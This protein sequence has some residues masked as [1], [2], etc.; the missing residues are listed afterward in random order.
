MKVIE[1]WM[2]VFCWQDVNMREGLARCESEGRFGKCDQAIA[3]EQCFE[4]TASSWPEI[5]VFS[6]GMGNQDAI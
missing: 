2:E 1:R 4:I 6:R 3:K 5:V